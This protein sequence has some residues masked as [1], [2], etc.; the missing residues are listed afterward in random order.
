MEEKKYILPALTPELIEFLIYAME[1]N[2]ETFLDLEEGVVVYSSEIDREEFK[3]NPKRFLNPPVWS[4][5]RGYELML[6]Y[7]ANLPE[8]NS[9]TKQ[10]LIKVLN[11]KK[12]GVFRRFKDVL[13]NEKKLI[14]SWYEFKNSRMEKVIQSWY[15]D[16]QDSDDFDEIDQEMMLEDFS[17]SEEKNIPKKIEK[18]FDKHISNNSILRDLWK[19]YEDK[20]AIIARNPEED[21]IASIVFARVGKQIC[22]L[23]YWVS[24]EVR[25]LG[26]FSLMLDKLREN[27]ISRILFPLEQKADYLSKY[28][29]SKGSHKEI[30]FVSIQPKKE[31]NKEKLD[32]NMLFL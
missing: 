16:L 21:P 29:A 5:A 6:D 23:Y 12:R 1:N 2:E 15:M 14:E 22:V 27:E 9:D 11:S 4:S 13:S 32:E 3:K 8:T 17:I 24:P 28:L 19:V 10:Q 18:G 26:I 30:E 7:V 31:S 25:G 20:A